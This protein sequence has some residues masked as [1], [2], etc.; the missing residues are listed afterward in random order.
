VG[1]GLP[2]GALPHPANYNGIILNMRI[3][4]ASDLHWPN[5]N[6]VATFGRNLAHGLADAGHEVIVVAPSQTGKKY[7]EIDR[8]YRIVR[9][10][11][12]VFPFY[13]NFRISVSPYREVKR[14][15]ERFRPDIIHTQ[16][17]LG[18]GRAA[19]NASREYDIPWVATNHAMPE[20]LIDNLRLL[21]PLARPINYMLKELGARFYSGADY[22][23]MPTEA[24]LEMLK[25]DSFH[26]PHKAISCGI[27]LS[28]FAP[29]KVPDE[30]Y[31]RFGIPKGKPVILYVGR[32]DAEKHISILIRAFDKVVANRDI[33]C[34]VVGKGTDADNLHDLVKEL[35]VEDK[36]IFTGRVEDEDL[37]LLQRI[38]EVFVMPSPVELQ[39]LAMLE[40]MASG[41]PVLAVNVGALYELCH[42]GENGYLFELDDW[43]QL[44]EQLA[45]LLDDPKLRKR[46]SE[47]SL[48][49]AKTHDLSHTIEEFVQLYKHVVAMRSHPENS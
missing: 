28:R 23:T 2:C 48:Q 30:V 33:H 22:V 39:C 11:S 32:L 35:G 26:A 1:R 4:I 12:V 34:V 40:A 49:I 47:K 13:Q 3:L 42:D 15:V 44:A 6:G 19:V 21:A 10:A 24:A 18:I 5:I 41:S 17:P 46:M 9:T 16:T 43:E 29:G 20:N 7:E 14:I 31:E 36:V 37:P 8:N 38:G 27:D 45:K 25:G